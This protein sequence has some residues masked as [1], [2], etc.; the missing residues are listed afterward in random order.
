MPNV[1]KIREIIEEAKDIKT[2]IFRHNLDAKPGQF[3]NVWIPRVDEKPFSI[4]YQDH[5][6][7]GITVSKVGPFSEKLHE[8]N[9]GDLLG[10]RGPYGNPFSIQGS[11]G[12]NVVLVGGG[13]GTAPL[14][15]LAE[16][17]IKNEIET[18]FIIGAKSKE[19]LLFEKRMKK[20]G[21]KTYFA[22]DD[23][24]HGFKG[25]TTDV[26][27]SIL[28]KGEKKIDKVYAC[29]PE[30]MLRKIVEICGQKNLPCEI[31]LERYMKCG[32]GVCGHCCL[33]DSGLR[34]CVDGPVFSGEVANQIFEFG[35]HRRDETGK[36]I[37][38]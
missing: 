17:S 3:V 10:F 25:F 36:K 2:F 4:S 37:R 33:D 22:T 5:E 16:E 31:S 15:F 8:L 21:I 6:K 13:C 9:A 23:G 24:S 27:A 7:F 28:G 26:L 19:Y 35:R 29:G 34:V 11:E 20:S 30:M 1:L 32:F 12:K 18:H 14:A 38:I